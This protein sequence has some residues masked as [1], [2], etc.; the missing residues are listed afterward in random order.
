FDNGEETFKQLDD[1]VVL[2]LNANL[3]A[4]S[5][6]VTTAL[7]LTE[8]SDIVFMGDTKGGA[9]DITDEQALD[10]LH[11]PNPHGRPNSDVIVPWVNGLDVT[12]RP[13]GMFIIDFGT[14]RSESAS[15]NYEEPFGYIV[16]HV[17]PERMTN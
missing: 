17:K 1:K 4:V 13:R 7:Q 6:D 2:S 5:A 16:E 15:A 8:N 9:F 3:T 10:M 11:L 12:R 14:A